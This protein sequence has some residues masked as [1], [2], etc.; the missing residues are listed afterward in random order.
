MRS[1]PKAAIMVLGV[2]LFNPLSGFAQQSD[3]TITTEA[4]TQQWYRMLREGR[5]HFTFGRQERAL[6]YF[7]E[8]LALAQTDEQRVNTYF[9]I[10]E[11][12]EGW[13]SRTK[14]IETY[15]AILEAYPASGYTPRILARLG[16]VHRS[17]TLLPGNLPPEQERK[18]V[19]TEMTN[20]N[21]ARFFEQAVSSG[22]A[23][24]IW[25]LFSRSGLANIYSESGQQ[26]KAW[27]IRHDLATLD[28]Y[29]I[30]TP[31]YIGPYARINA[32][33]VTW[34]ERLDKDRRRAAAIREAWRKRL[35][36][37]SVVPGNP[38]QTVVNMQALIDRYPGTEIE[39]K[40]REKQQEAAE[41]IK[42]SLADPDAALP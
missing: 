8:G 29:A 11:A 4:M 2:L 18:I 28:V 27:E 7:Q 26:A 5:R 36:T 35:V 33:E 13:S 41:E 25:V 16:E 19:A 17:I 22:T 30:R 24:N 12:Y 3:D 31:Q 21:A 15:K 32:P 14:A 38:A 1:T 39:T 34:A 40:A 10:A 20:E 23:S 37:W 42:R 6:Q 9:F